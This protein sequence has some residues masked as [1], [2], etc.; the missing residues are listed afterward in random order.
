MIVPE[1]I[2]PRREGRKAR[3]FKVGFDGSVKVVLE[4]RM[5]VFVVSTGKDDNAFAG[6]GG[7]GIRALLGPS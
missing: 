7:L 3:S 2:L 5:W 4:E 6:L 1:D